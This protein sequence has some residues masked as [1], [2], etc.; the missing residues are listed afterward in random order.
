MK[1]VL[2]ERFYLPRAISTIKQ[3]ADHRKCSSC[4][5]A[6]SSLKKIEPPTGNIKEFRIPRPY[7]DECN[8][9]Y[10]V[11]YY[12]FKGPIKVNDDRKFKQ[13]SKKCPRSSR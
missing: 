13:V 11:C 3:A 5:L 1:T 7:G 6:R 4:A 8:R 12:D 2:N 10:K 9:P